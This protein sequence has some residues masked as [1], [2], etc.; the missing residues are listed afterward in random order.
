M[1]RI[2]V[3]LPEKIVFENSEIPKDSPTLSL[4]AGAWG[5]GPLAEVGVVFDITGSELPLL[6]PHDIR[7]LSKW[8][9]AVADDLEGK[10]AEKKHK[11]RNHYRDEEDDEFS[12]WRK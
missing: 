10:R 6:S 4:Q 2:T 1:A 8:L 12:Q 5:D 7:K 11:G 3:N 9:T